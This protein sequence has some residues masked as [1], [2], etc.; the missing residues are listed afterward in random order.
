MAREN[1]ILMEDARIIFKNFAGKEGK[2]NREGDR[3]FCVLLDEDMA[4][5]LD[6]DGWNVKALRAR[7]EGDPDQPYLQVTVSYK[8]RPPK[9]VMITSRGRT[10]LSEDEIEL[11]DWADIRQVDLIV[12]P[13]HWVVSE[14]SGIKAY[15]KSIF[16]TIEE[17]ALDLKYADVDYIDP[18]AIP[19]RAGRVEE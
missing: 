12:R 5:E 3:N 2:Y 1:T 10:D 18:E 13:Y 9:V 19:A 11:L 14:K 8:G 4:K 15:L 16:I 6:E 7:E 17:D